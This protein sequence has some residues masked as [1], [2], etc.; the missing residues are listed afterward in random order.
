MAVKVFA[1]S[2][3]AVRIAGGDFTD[4]SQVSEASYRTV[5]QA[6]QGAT[7]TWTVKHDPALAIAASRE[8]AAAQA[9]EGAR[10]QWPE[11]EGYFAH[12][13][14]AHEITREQLEELLGEM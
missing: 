3:F 13:A 6:E 4:I 11:S 5:T 12:H 9:L 8:E 10:Q 1:V 7:P 2:V 14:I